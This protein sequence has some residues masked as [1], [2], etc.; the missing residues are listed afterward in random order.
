MAVDAITTTRSGYVMGITGAT[1]ANVVSDADV[2]F[3]T[4]IVVEGVILSSTHVSNA[5][6]ADLTLYES[7]DSSGSPS[8]A[9]VHLEAA[10]DATAYTVSAVEAPYGAEIKTTANADCTVSWY[11]V[12]KRRTIAPQGVYSAN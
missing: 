7:G 12:S 9:K 3:N 10:A 4:H 8:G 11:T 2:D 6:T 1:T 5:T